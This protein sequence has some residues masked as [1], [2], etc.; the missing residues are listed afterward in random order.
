MQSPTKN[1]GEPRTSK[2][3][4]GRA[5]DMEVE[6][7]GQRALDLLA[8]SRHAPSALIR[9]AT[10]PGRGIHGRLL[11]TGR[12]AIAGARLVAPKGGERSTCL[13]Q[14]KDLRSRGER[15]LSLTHKKDICNFV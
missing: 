7:Q 13:G 10:S 4:K 12:R 9:F 1:G 5:T 8:I 6:V 15:R 3:S 11:E 2:V 14:N